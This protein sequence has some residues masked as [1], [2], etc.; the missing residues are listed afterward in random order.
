MHQQR[1][2]QPERKPTPSV[3]SLNWPCKII[4]L[5]SSN[6]K[7]AAAFCGHKKPHDSRLSLSVVDSDDSKCQ[8][9]NPWNSTCDARKDNKI[10]GITKAVYKHWISAV[11]VLIMGISCWKRYHKHLSFEGRW[12]PS[13]YYRPSTGGF[14]SWKLHHFTKLFIYTWP[15]TQNVALLHSANNRSSW[16]ILKSW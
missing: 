8:K 13:I 5:L 2:M 3:V 16:H 1:R 10:L 9:K 11:L 15:Y 6:R 4:I 12:E 7:A 14:S